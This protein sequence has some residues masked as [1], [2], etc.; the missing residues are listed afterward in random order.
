MKTLTKALEPRSE[1]SLLNRPCLPPRPLRS[2]GPFHLPTAHHLAGASAA[3][4]AAGGGVTEIHTCVCISV[5]MTWGIAAQAFRA[6]L[7]PSERRLDRYRS[8]PNLTDLLS[9]GLVADIDRRPMLELQAA[10]LQ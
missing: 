7:L 2:G 6:T 8:E 5:E 1:R 10:V 3:H 9:T 4:T